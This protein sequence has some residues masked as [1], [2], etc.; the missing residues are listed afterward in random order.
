MD[1]SDTTDLIYHLS[2]EVP[3]I[4]FMMIL[5]SAL[6]LV[7]SMGFASMWS[8]FLLY[9]SQLSPFLIQL[10]TYSAHL[11][12]LFLFGTMIYHGHQKPPDDNDLCR[13]REKRA[14][15]QF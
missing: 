14:E 5:V 2:I 12:W 11:L 15:S 4:I 9:G 8:N 3:F 13:H 1:I 10:W 7:M 6:V